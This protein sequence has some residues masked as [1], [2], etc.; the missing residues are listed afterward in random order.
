M[1]EAR[2]ELRLDSKGEEGVYFS[3]EHPAYMKMYALVHIQT[4]SR[5]RRR[6]R[7]ADVFEGW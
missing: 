6:R 4:D 5:T 1:T 7:E 2:K 3:W